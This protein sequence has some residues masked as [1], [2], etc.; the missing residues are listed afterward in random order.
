MRLGTLKLDQFEMANKGTPQGSVISPLLFNIAMTKL[1]NILKGIHRIRHA[2]Y[3]D[4]LT[5]WTTG[6]SSG[7]Q[8]DALQE[9]VNR[10]EN[11]LNARGL[12]C[13]PEKFELLL[14]KARTRG[15]PPTGKIPEPRLWLKGVQI[16]KME[17]LRVLGLDIHKDGSGAATLPKLQATVTQVA[18]LVRRVSNKRHGL[19]K[20]DTIKLI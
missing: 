15:R 13:A 3:A 6:G 18:H 4:Y 12:T 8:Q 20:H 14:L 11:Y 16:P 10:T 1:L 9:A 17:S 2:L 7:A 19:K 5:I